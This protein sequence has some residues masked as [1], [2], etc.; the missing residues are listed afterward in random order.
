MRVA[1]GHTVLRY[2]PRSAT[3]IYTAIRFQSADVQAGQ[4]L[5]ASG[6]A[7]QHCGHSL[8]DTGGGGET[9]YVMG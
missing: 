8:V 5:A 7:V 4:R 9:P 6:I 2:L 3:F 1:V